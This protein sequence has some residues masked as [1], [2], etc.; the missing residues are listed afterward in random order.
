MFSSCVTPHLAT[1]TPSPTS[2]SL[3]QQLGGMRSQL[4]DL[5]LA[6][7]RHA[8]DSTAAQQR[9]ITARADAQSARDEADASRD[10]T[11]HALARCEA[12]RA[13]V[14]AAAAAAQ[15]MSKEAADAQSAVAARDSEL[16]A[17]KDA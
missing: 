17:S 12:M 15:R 5:R 9:A 14:A 8:S 4:A 7:E 11:R 6:S 16:Y 3:L 2:S 10:E 13:E 1:M